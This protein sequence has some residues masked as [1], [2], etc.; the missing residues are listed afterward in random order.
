MEI[1][2]ILMIVIGTLVF[3][4]QVL[5]F[6]RSSKKPSTLGDDFYLKLQTELQSS[7]FDGVQK[8]LSQHAQSVESVIKAASGEAFQKQS[9]GFVEVAKNEFKKETDF[10]KKEIE[11]LVKP[12]AESL[13]VY[14]KEL[15]QIES[16]RNKEYG[17]LNQLVKSLVDSNEKLKLETHHLVNALKRPTV[18]G[19][20]GEVQL[21][22]I[23]ELAGMTDHIDFTEQTSVETE[24]GR[25]RPDMIVHLP[26][27]RSIVVDSKAVLA[28]Y[29]E[30]ETLTD[31]T[32][33][34]AALAR[35]AQSIRTRVTE[36]SRKNY[37]EQFQNAP[38]FVVLFIPAEA[39][40]S[41]ALQ[42]MPQLLEEAFRLKIVIASPS[43]LV[44]LLRAIAFGW[45]N[46][47]LAENSKKIAEN[48]TRLYQAMTVWTGH[49]SQ[50]GS[51]LDKAVKNY[52][53]SV[54]SLEK[55]VLPP[56]RRMKELGLTTKDELQEVKEVET[57]VRETVAVES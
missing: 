52:N 20:W 45:R 8:M 40:L 5:F 32:A 30:A 22:R 16:L 46:E 6:L 21:K 11:S 7:T 13:S 1:F 57:L 42:E 34:K 28:A 23:V 14:K 44:S 43:T 49:L 36:L 4:A 18:R 17:G 37:W 48:A 29:F 10:Q 55:S 9:Q 12:L 25:L 33:R 27:D 2:E 51:S 31:E 50:L 39:F 26:A 15:D 38:D 24:E 53:A 56:A 35:H 3:G 47:Q 54:G 19:R 41:A